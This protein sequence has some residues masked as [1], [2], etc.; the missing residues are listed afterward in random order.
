MGSGAMSHQEPSIQELVERLRAGDPEARATLLCEYLPHLERVLTYEMQTRGI[1]LT[2][3]V[4]DLCQSTARRFLKNGERFQFRNEQEFFACLLR[5]GERLMD[6][7]AAEAKRRRRSRVTLNDPQWQEL[8]DPA[9]TPP[10]RAAASDQWQQLESELTSAERDLVEQ[11]VA[12]HSWR[13]V[14]AWFGISASAARM[15]MQ[16]V[17]E[18]LRRKPR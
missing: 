5:I 15:R 13:E 7:R 4:H 3:D 14:G 12:T 11:S 6:R 18:R 1:E 9:P 2:C 16:R 10:R 8:E 17:A